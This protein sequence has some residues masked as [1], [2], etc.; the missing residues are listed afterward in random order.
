MTE[1]LTV[2][3]TWSPGNQFSGLKAICFWNIFLSFFSPYMYLLVCLNLTIQEQ[4]IIQEFGSVG[5]VC[6]IEEST[7]PQNLQVPKVMSQLSTIWCTRF[8]HANAFHE[9]VIIVLPIHSKFT[10]SFMMKICNFG[11]MCAGGYLKKK[12]TS[13]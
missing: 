3:F 8:T 2:S 11:S 9:E 5:G 10:Y 13:W 12:K 7:G 4:D 1:C 6:S